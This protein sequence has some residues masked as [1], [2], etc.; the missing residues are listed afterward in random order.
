[1]ENWNNPR[2]IFCLKVIVLDSCNILHICKIKNS[3]FLPI[4]RFIIIWFISLSQFT[5][6]G[7]IR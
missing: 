2:L 3:F 1:M 4:E 7:S 6:I 5:L